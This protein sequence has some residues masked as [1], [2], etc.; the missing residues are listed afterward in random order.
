M[1]F[2]GDGFVQFFCR[3]LFLCWRFLYLTVLCRVV[4]VG[5]LYTGCFL[6][7]AII[8]NLIFFIFKRIIILIFFLLPRAFLLP[9]D[10]VLLFFKHSSARVR[11]MPFSTLHTVIPSVVEE[12]RGNEPFGLSLYLLSPRGGESVEREE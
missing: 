10:K 4:F 6:L 5:L 3:Q 9:R 2:L 11:C 7:A 1:L 8:N 12:S